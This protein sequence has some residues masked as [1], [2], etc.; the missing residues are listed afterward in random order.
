MSKGSSVSWSGLLKDTRQ[1]HSKRSS[2]V[3][4]QDILS[5]LTSFHNSAFER[6]SLIPTFIS[7]S[8]DEVFVVMLTILSD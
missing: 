7:E 3:R 4:G 6:V 8:A 5:I 1:N 2:T